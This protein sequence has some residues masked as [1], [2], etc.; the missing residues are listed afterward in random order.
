MIKNAST[1]LIGEEQLK[2]SHVYLGFGVYLMTRRASDCNSFFAVIP[3]LVRANESLIVRDS[4][5]TAHLLL[6][7]SCRV[8]LLQVIGIG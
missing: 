6:E 3:F 1:I 2:R 4:W 8:L 5:S 7:Q